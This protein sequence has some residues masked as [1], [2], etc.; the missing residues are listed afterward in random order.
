MWYKKKKLHHIGQLCKQIYFQCSDISE[1]ERIW[2][3]VVIVYFKVLHT[4]LPG[5][6]DGNHK[7]PQSE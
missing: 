5:V 4:H 2:E 6:T 3:E 7:N 1:L